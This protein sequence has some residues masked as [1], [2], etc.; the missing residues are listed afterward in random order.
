[1]VRRAM[2]RVVRD[3]RFSAIWRDGFRAY[4]DLATRKDGLCADWSWFDT[5]LGG[6]PHERL[7]QPD[8]RCWLDRRGG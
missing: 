2:R 3:R 6:G 4:R 5:R 8:E 1:M 7:V